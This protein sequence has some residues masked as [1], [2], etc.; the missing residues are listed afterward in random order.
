MVGLA[1]LALS[2]CSMSADHLHLYPNDSR[3]EDT[4]EAADNIGIRF[5]PTRGEIGIG[6]SD[7]GLP[8]DN[9]VEAEAYILED[10]THLVVIYH[11]P[12]PASML[13]VGI[14]PCSPFSV[15]LELM[16]DAALLARDKGVFLHTHLAENE[17]DIAYALEKSVVVRDNMLKNLV[18]LEALFFALIA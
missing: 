2:G 10:G 6:D 1:E 14:A 9:L 18:G 16:R 15:S 3:L 17:E 12:N 5:F 4:I 8:P 7:A 11:D 13:K